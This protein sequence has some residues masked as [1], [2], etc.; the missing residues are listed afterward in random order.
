MNI[1]KTSIII[2]VYN[3]EKYLFQCLTSAI[4]QTLQDIEIIV[5]NDAST[6]KSLEII[7]SFQEKG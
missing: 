2:P 1:P 4:C 5:I 6:D 3:T 7:K